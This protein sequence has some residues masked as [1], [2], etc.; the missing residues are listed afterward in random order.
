[1]MVCC[2]MQVAVDVAIPEVF[3]GLGGEAIYIGMGFIVGSVYGY[4]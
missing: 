3:G 1:M 4:W 2:S